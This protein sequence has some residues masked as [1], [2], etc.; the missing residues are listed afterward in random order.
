MPPLPTFVPLATLSPWH[1]VAVLVILAAA[2]LG[3]VTRRRAPAIAFGLLWIVVTGSVAANVIVPTGVI[4][5]ERVL[6]LPSVGAAIVAGALW[7]LL[8]RRRI[9]T[10]L[11]I[12][13]L[14]MLELWF[15]MWI[16]APANEAVMRPAA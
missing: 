1:V 13:A 4:I 7:A 2:F 5:A 10:V 3:W 16:D 9:V 8:P 6:Y 12:W 15:R 14:L 11:T